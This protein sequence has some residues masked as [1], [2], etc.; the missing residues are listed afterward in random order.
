MNKLE[1]MV[2]SRESLILSIAEGLSDELNDELF[3]MIDFGIDAF[4]G[5]DDD[6]I[7]EPE[8]EEESLEIV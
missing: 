3:D 5:I 6:L 7:L 1:K 4:F 2:I 8:E